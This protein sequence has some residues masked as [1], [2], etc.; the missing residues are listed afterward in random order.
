MDVIFSPRVSH[1]HCHTGN[2]NSKRKP[3]VS[4]KMPWGLEF[5]E[6]LPLESQKV[7][8]KGDIQKGELQ[9]YFFNSSNTLGW[10]LKYVC[11][12]HTARN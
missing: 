1:S 6:T 10:P 11:V 7:T 2:K 9:V 8:Y 3:S 5:E 4:D 12:D